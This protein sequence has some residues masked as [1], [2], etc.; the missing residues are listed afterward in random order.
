MSRKPR[1]EFSLTVN[2]AAKAATISA[3]G[4][5]SADRHVA[6]YLN[7]VYP[8]DASPSEGDPVCAAFWRAK[9]GL[10]PDW[11]ATVVTAPTPDELP[12]GAV[13]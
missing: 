6:S 5:A 11:K 10:F 7:T 8:P 3:A 1:G 9:A 4:W 13:A 12:A 2:G